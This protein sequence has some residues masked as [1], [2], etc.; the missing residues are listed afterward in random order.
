MTV[1][2]TGLPSCSMDEDHVTLSFT[3]SKALGKTVAENFPGCVCVCV[4]GALDPQLIMNE[5][6]GHGLTTS[7]QFQPLQN[8]QKTSP[9]TFSACVCILEVLNVVQ[10]TP[11][12]LPV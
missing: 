7:R 11:E 2:S 9:I 12:Q 6:H 10:S 8:K 5:L 3:C 4:G 1:E